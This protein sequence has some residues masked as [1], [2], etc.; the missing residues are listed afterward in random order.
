MMYS[1]E[2]NAPSED[3]TK[4]MVNQIPVTIWFTKTIVARKPNTY[5]KFMFF[6]A[7]Y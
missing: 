3:G 4:F 5:Q 2:A 7:G 6:G 1:T